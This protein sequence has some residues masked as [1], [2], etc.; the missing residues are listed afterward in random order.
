MHFA[1][2][3]GTWIYTLLAVIPRDVHEGHKSFLR[4]GDA[5][6]LLHVLFP[7]LLL[8]KKLALSSDV[9]S[10]AFGENVLAQRLDVRA[11]DD[12]LTDGGLY[13]NLEELAGNELLQ[14]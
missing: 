11:H 3:K 7:L 13:G 1:S 5:P 4:D 12:L 6:H 14:L 2:Q 9:A 8:F 10:V